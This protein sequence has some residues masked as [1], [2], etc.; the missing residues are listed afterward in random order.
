[1]ND[2]QFGV[3]ELPLPEIGPAEILVNLSVTGL[4]DTDF[5]LVSGAFGDTCRILGHEGISRV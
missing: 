1:M 2:I 5:A 3:I 4:C